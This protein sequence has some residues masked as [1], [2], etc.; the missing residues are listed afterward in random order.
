MWHHRSHLRWYIHL[1]ILKWH[2]SPENLRLIGKNHLIDTKE[3]LWPKI[4]CQINNKRK[5]LWLKCGITYSPPTHPFPSTSVIIKFLIIKG[6]WEFTA[7]QPHPMS[8]SSL[9]LYRNS[10]WQLLKCLFNWINI[11]IMRMRKC[12]R[13][14]KI[15]KTEKRGR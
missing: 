14:Y 3:E 10:Y 5:F 13:K 1:I 7:Y 4:F 8:K 11:N 15:K 9:L 2:I 12:S 6:S